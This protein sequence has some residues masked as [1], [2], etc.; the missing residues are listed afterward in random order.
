VCEEAPAVAV[1]A[2]VRLKAKTLGVYSHVQA[3]MK[4]EE[5]MDST[6]SQGRLVYS[7]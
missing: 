4:D 1:V 5:A 7:W 2:T 3:T 6:F